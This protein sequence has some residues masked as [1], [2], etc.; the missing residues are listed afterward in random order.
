[1]VTPASPCLGRR[2]PPLSRT[3]AASRPGVPVAGDRPSPG[4][5]KE[6]GPAPCDLQNSSPPLPFP[7]A[8]DCCFRAIL[9]NSSPLTSLLRKASCSAPPPCT[10]SWLGKGVKCNH[11]P[12]VCYEQPGGR[13]GGGQT[14][15]EQGMAPRCLMVTLQ[16]AA[17]QQ[18]GSLKGS[19]TF[20][21]SS[22]LTDPVFLFEGLAQS[23]DFF[24]PFQIQII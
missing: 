18:L 4:I 7:M 23:L 19:G 8:S 6:G 14:G 17:G 13:Q 2:A 1:M 5:S 21:H 3:A 10:S 15:R 9:K 16:T 22:S 20:L 11:T 12:S 24:F